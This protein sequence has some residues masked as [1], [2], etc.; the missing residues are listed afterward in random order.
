M[1]EL[2][3]YMVYMDDGRDVFKVPVPAASKKEAEQYVQG[4]GEIISIKDV[5]NEYTPSLKYITDVLRGYRF[6]EAEIGFI[7]RTLSMTGIAQ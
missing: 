4:N 6:G 1:K 2:K 5:T 3:K 7:T